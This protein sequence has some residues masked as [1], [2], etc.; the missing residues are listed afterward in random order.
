M[1][2]VTTDEGPCQWFPTSPHNVAYSQPVQNLNLSVNVN[3]SGQMS[4][5]PEINVSAKKDEDLTNGVNKD[6]HGRDEEDDSLPAK[7]MQETLSQPDHGAPTAGVPATESSTDHSAPSAGVPATESSSDNDTN[8]HAE[9]SPQVH[10]Q[11]TDDPEGNIDDLY[12]K[13]ARE[14]V[15]EIPLDEHNACD[16]QEQQSLPGNYEMV[17][18]I[19][20]SSQGDPVSEQIENDEQEQEQERLL[21]DCKMVSLDSD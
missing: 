15:S 16:D 12:E 20:L 14:P 13:E 6:N 19:P 11:C 4:N 17:P 8:S 5:P 18:L 7:G 1:P 3:I 2:T 10:K 9:G 21:R